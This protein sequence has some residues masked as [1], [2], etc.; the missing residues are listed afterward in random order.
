MQ[1]HRN[2]FQPTSDPPR[3]T[4]KKTAAYAALILLGLGLVRLFELNYIRSPFAA[5][6]TPTRS[7]VSWAEEGKSFFDAGNLIKAILAYQQAVVVDPKNAQLWTELARIQTYSSALLL[8]T[9]EKQ[10]RMQQAQDSIN[11]ALAIDP[12]F[13]QG[14][15]IKTLVLD[16][17]ASNPPDEATRQQ[18]LIDAYQASAAALTRD[19]QNAYALAFRAEV[20]AD[21]SNWSTALDVGAQAVGLGSGIMD[22]HRAYAYVLE[23]NADYTGAIDEYIKAIRINPNLP[24]LHMSLGVNYRKMGEIATTQQTSQDMIDSAIN[25][26][27]IAAS[28]N[29][30][31]PGPYLS[32]AQTYANQGDFFAAE[33]NAEQALSLD[34]TNPIVYGRLGVIY[35]HAKN[36]ET[37]IKVLKCAVR[38]C[39]AVDNEEQSVDVAGTS[40]SANTLD[41][42]YT[43]GSVMAFYGNESG[44]CT[45]A[46]SIFSQLR[47]S[48]WYDST[49]EGIIREG[50]VI[51]AKFENETPTP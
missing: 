3:L 47:A 37:A 41:I 34:K 45:E 46:R 35:Y 25:E 27:A 38:G 39:L 15:A 31:D 4:V 29:N 1:L 22:V 36:Y 30:K 17:T 26:F 33:L 14:F 19:P 11:K 5:P 32:I 20:L 8:S 49:V 24:F 50:E 13:A 16:W 6:S 12:E 28:L 7:A 43:Y 51:C 9:V 42:Y 2:R 10:Q 18:N 44:N 23:S 48:P 40:L 21:Q